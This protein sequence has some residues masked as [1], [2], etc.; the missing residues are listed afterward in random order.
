MLGKLLGLVS[1]IGVVFS[2]TSSPTISLS[3]TITTTLSATETSTPLFYYTSYPTYDP[4]NSTV[5]TTITTDTTSNTGTTSSMIMGGV[6]VGIAS[7]GAIG[8]AI[9]Y[10]RKG[11]SLSG[12][13]KIAYQNREKI[14][15]NL[16]KLPLDDLNNKLGN[17]VDLTK[18]EELK[19]KGEDL[20]NNLPPSVIEKIK[21]NITGEKLIE[22]VENP[23]KFKEDLKEDIATI[24]HSELGNLSEHTK[25]ILGKLPI[26]DAMKSQLEFQVKAMIEQKLKEA[27]SK[28]DNSDVTI[29]F[30]EVPLDL[31]S[32][33]QPASL[34][35]HETSPHSNDESKSAAITIKH[36]KE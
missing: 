14:I 18:F 12:L 29:D 19:H 25:D 7:I 24:A 33:L 11:G 6:A 15:E 21:E 28:K 22:L 31:L 5:V 30:K 9:N 3:S 1:L 36:T 34:I 10:F 23:E 13:A 16:N 27:I 4:N 2:Q 32:I 20:F 26:P 8:F 35:I 17:K